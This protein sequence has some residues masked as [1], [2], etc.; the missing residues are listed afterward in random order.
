MITPRHDRTKPTPWFDLFWA[1]KGWFAIIG[2][3]AALAFT[4]FSVNTY[5]T[6]ADFAAR[7]VWVSAEIT[8]MRIS[9]SDDDTDYLVTFRY[10]VDGKGYSRQRD[11]GSGYYR[12]HEVGDMVEI[13]ILPNRPKTFEYREGQ[14]QS[15]AV[16]MQIIAGVAGIVGC[17]MLW[18][19]GS[20]ANN[21]V[22][23]RRKGRRTVA[24]IEGFVDIKNSGKPTGRGYM[25]FRT[26]DGLRGQSLNG[27]IRKLRALGSDTEIVVFVRGKDVWWEGD[28]GPRAEHQSKLPRVPR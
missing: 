20:K 8:R 2:G 7:G 22:L 3:A 18:H 23:A 11:T 13:K 9:R 16:V 17:G 6:A 25:M 19:S 26:A 15:S 5:K 28:V 24:T 21:A 12:A 1:T 27:D 10:H 14:T 4:I